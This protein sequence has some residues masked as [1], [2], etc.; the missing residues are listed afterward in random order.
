LESSSP[1][2]PTSRRGIK[3]PSGTAVFSPVS[4]R[5]TA[6]VASIFGSILVA[7]AVSVAAAAPRVRRL[8]GTVERAIH[9]Q[10]P[11]RGGVAVTNKE[12]EEWDAKTER[13]PI[14]K[15]TFTIFAGNRRV[16]KPV[17]RFKT[18]GAGRFAVNLPEGVFCVMAG[19][20]EE[21]ATEKAPA[22]AAPGRYIDA[23]CL[24]DRA[25][26]C[27]AELYVGKDATRDVKVTLDTY[28]PCP[29]QWAQPCYRG[30]MPP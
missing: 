9:A 26:V 12:M 18:D 4:R 15:T 22:P 17:T 13:S 6:L 5:M 21:A 1:D 30:P 3:N 8:T 7:G 24:R 19:A 27:D 20:L 11:C 16:G 14:A 23:D 28:T 25:L 29:Q 2:D 10:G